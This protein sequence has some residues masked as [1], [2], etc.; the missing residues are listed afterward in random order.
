M[1]IVPGLTT[2][3]KISTVILTMGVAV[4]PNNVSLLI[5]TSLFLY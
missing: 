2:T 5:R 3:F 1:E 4:S